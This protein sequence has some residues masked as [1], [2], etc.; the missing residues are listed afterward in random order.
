MQ[1]QPKP[2]NETFLSLMK[3]INKK[4]KDKIDEEYW[5]DIFSNIGDV[6]GDTPP[7]VHSTIDASCLTKNP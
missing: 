7:F 4:L 2:E 6:F 3:T 5:M 1:Q